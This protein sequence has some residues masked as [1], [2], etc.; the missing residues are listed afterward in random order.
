[1]G[2]IFFSVFSKRL[3]KYMLTNRFTSHNQKGF[4]ANTP[5]CL[6]HSFAMCEALL[7]AKQNQRQVVVAWLD[8]CNVL[9]N[10]TLYSLP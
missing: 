1:M 7:D 4:K 9:S 3:E 8:L 6:E 2:K 10:T 5:G